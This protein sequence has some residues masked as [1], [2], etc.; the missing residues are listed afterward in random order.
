MNLTFSE[1]NTEKE[2]ENI[3]LFTNYNF[4]PKRK[5]LLFPAI[6]SNFETEKVQPEEITQ[7]K[8]ISSKIYLP[9]YRNIKKEMFKMKSEINSLYNIKRSIFGLMKSRFNSVIYQNFVRGLGKYFFGPYGI[10]TKKY[11]FLKEYYNYKSYLNT[12]IYAGKL[13]YYN[14]P[15]KKFNQVTARENEV[16]KRRL[17]L[18]NNFAVVFDKNDIISAKAETS[19]RL[20]KYRKNFV[21]INRNKYLNNLNNSNLQQINEEND[22]N[23]NNNNKNNNAKL[24][25]KKKIQLLLNKNKLISKI[26]KDDNGINSNNNKN[27]NKKN[28]F[29]FITEYNKN[30]Q[31]NKFVKKLASKT[32]KRNFINLNFSRSLNKKSNLFLTQNTFNSKL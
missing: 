4:Y 6:F 11:K 10:V 12:R 21:E 20:I 24:K 25:L 28:N 5:R 9:V 18:S 13:E 23:N 3:H 31:Y 29:T 1:N 2:K 14:L 27:K 22:M 30:V 7:K 17:S 32:P 26:K 16:K 8:K 19:K 15:I